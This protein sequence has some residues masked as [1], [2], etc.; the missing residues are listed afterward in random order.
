MI[1]L[2]LLGVVDKVDKFECAQD[3]CTAY[4]LSLLFPNLDTDECADAEL[5]CGLGA[6]CINLNGTFDCRCRSGFQKTKEN[7]TGLSIS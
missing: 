5:V 3:L 7:C 4:F 2:Q 1:A 6:D